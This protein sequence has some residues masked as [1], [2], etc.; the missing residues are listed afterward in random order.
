MYKI[1]DKVYVFLKDTHNNAIA[2]NG[3][4]RNRFRTIIDIR[5]N[6]DKATYI[7]KMDITDK[8]IMVQEDHGIFTFYDM[9]ELLDAI[10]SLDVS[11]SVKEKYA[12]LINRI[13]QNEEMEN[14]QYRF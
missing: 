10:R 4:H 9:N 2:L 6:V 3:L 5:E 11:E 1:N 8:E 12:E 13:L 7:V 14:I